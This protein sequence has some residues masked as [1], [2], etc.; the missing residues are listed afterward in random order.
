[1]LSIIIKYDYY[2]YIFGEWINRFF[3]TSGCIG[4]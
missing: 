4:I 2:M 3:L 1:M